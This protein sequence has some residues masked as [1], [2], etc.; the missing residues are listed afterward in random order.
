MPE[1]KLIGWYHGCYF[2]AHR[3]SDG[4]RLR[5]QD[6]AEEG[7][8]NCFGETF[9]SITG[10]FKSQLKYLQTHYGL[11][12][13]NYKIMWECDWQALKNDPLESLPPAMREEAKQVRLFMSEHYKERPLFR[14]APRTSLR[15]GKVEAFKLAWEKTKNLTQRLM[16]MDFNR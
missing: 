16:Y 7:T 12:P 3:P 6:W 10:R 11:Y 14:L 2:H 5:K 15:G 4:C 8:K 1:R 9:S 13:R